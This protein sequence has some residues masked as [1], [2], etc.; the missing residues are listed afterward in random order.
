MNLLEYVRHPER[1][2]G[3]TLRQLRALTERYPYYQP[4]RLLMLRN[5]YQLH[6]ASFGE[7]LRK[8]AMFVPDRRALFQLIESYK[9]VLEPVR[10]HV[11]QSGRDMEDEPADR[12]QS[13]ID[14]FLSE[15]PDEKK[16]KPR[17]KLTVADATT[18][19]MA[20]LMQC[21][22]AA[23]T[24]TTEAPPMN[25][26]DLID[27]FIGQG[28]RR[29]VLSQEPDETLQTPRLEDRS[30]AEDSEDYLTETLAKIYIKQARY[31]K[32]IEIIRKLSLK[33]PKKNRYFADQI[34]FLE[35]LIINNKNK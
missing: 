10:K 1:M 16:E 31:E 2:D 34:R 15:L 18:D 19:Y 22:D 27:D 14:N 7:E 28:E 3:E 24:E 20:Y 17:R 12:T 8:A 26:Q 23:G 5:L 29:I 6:D 32:A 33:Y 35:K 30:Q 13:L 4:A 9:Y 25:R 11:S 21:E